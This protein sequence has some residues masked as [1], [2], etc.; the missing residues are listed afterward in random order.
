[1]PTKFLMTWLR[2]A[3]F[4]WRQARLERKLAFLLAALPLGIG[5]SPAWTQVDQAVELHAF[6]GSAV[7]KGELVEVTDGAYLIETALGAL[8]IGL[9]EAECRGAAC[10]T[11]DRFDADFAIRATSEETTSLLTTLL[12]AYAESVGAVYRTS[13]GDDDGF[14]IVDSK[15]GRRLVAIDFLGPPA[16]GNADAANELRVIAAQ[17]LS[18]TDEDNQLLLALKGVALI[19][20]PDLQIDILNRLAVADLF[21]CNS[22]P[23]SSTGDGPLKLYVPALTTESFRTFKATVLDP[24]GLPLC[25]SVIQLDSEAAVAETVAR[26]PK[27]IGVIDLNRSH[28]ARALAIAECGITYLPS[29]FNLKAGEYPLARRL[30][31]EAPPLSQSSGAAQR[32]IEFAQSDLGQ[33]NIEG[34][35]WIGLNLE[36]EGANATEYRTARL[37]A[38]TNLVQ[39]TQPVYQFMQA[40]GDAI[41]LSTT[42]RFKSGAG[43]VG[44]Q[45]GLDQRAQRDLS[46]LVGYLQTNGV[47][48]FELLVFGFA[49]SSGDYGANLALSEQRA[50]SVAN[51]LATFGVPITAVAGFGE[52]LPIACN[53]SPEGRAKN[54]RVEV[55]LRPST[56]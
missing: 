11:L 23:T 17:G 2:R 8:R 35:G 42:F 56:S 27:A 10:P 33:E 46:R 7:I 24:Y 3:P 41:R 25:D 37:K 48:D 5:A 21:A 53:Q 28:D 44:G 4:A 51:H 9:D 29:P 43:N 31:L 30:L 36:A 49:D 19:A 15:S 22:S 50:Q 26:D 20:H 16:D 14:E 13:E 6:D 12:S 39:Q 55:W 1:M 45:A 38:A 32:F 18:A 54:R 34:S 47:S 52:E 40:T